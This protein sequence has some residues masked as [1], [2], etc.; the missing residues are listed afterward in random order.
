MPEYQKECP[1]RKATLI[2][3]PNTPPKKMFWGCFC[4]Y[5]VGPLEP[6]EGVINSEKYLDVLTKKVKSEMARK[7]PESSGI[8]QQDLVPCH[9]SQK[10]KYLSI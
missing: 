9:T 6:I 7:F 5:G 2:K 1:L 10:V 4:Y 8:F 3:L